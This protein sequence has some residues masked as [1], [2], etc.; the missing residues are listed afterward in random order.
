[1]TLSTC[2]HCGGH[3]PLGIDATNRCEECGKHVFSSPEPQPGDR[4][5]VDYAMFV[6]LV[7]E[8]D[9][10]KDA[11]ELIASGDFHEDGD[12]ARLALNPIT[13]K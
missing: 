13:A 10:L 2:E 3:I 4:I 7:N 11:L 12:I 8:R 9:R 6:K 5:N 1:M